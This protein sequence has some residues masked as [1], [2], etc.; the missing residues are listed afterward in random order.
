[1]VYAN[2]GFIRKESVG[3]KVLHR[4]AQKC[5]RNALFTSSVTP[6]LVEYI[7]AA[8]KVTNVQLIKN[9]FNSKLFVPS[10]EKFENFTMVFHG[11]IG[12]FQNP[13]LLIQVV[14]E[15]NRRN[16]KFHCIAI[17]SGSK[18]KVFENHPVK[19]LEFMGRLNNEDLAQ[20][21]KK[22]HVGL[23]FRTKDE[24]STRS[25]PVRVSEYIGIGI[26]T[27]LTPKSEGGDLLDAYQVGKSFNND[28]LQ[29]ICDFIISLKYNNDLYSFYKNNALRIRSNF[30]RETG[31]I[32]FVKNMQ[33]YLQDDTFKSVVEVP[34]KTKH[35]QTV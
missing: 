29:E 3:F 16:E 18:Q 24:I 30:S 34:S 7:K 2:S 9:G 22:A 14:E 5:Y 33:A 23:S 17:G 6:Q 11:N 1:L 19:N 10:A 20:I 25:I 15:L 8:G 27:V 13:M 12:Q 35:K 32:L 21:I 26:P 28:D 31:A 4:I